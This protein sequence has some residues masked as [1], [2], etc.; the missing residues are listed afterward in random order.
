MLRAPERRTQVVARTVRERLQVLEGRLQASCP[1][2]DA[3]L[4]ALDGLAALDGVRQHVGDA[5]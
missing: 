1:L 2:L 3:L 5:L 4:E